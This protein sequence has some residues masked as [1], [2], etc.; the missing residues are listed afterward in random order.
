LF[1]GVG[2]ETLDGSEGFFLAAAADEPPWGFRGEEDE[3]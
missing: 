1:L 2:A 3:D